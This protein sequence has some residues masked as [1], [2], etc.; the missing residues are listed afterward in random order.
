MPDVKI[1][2][3]T[4]SIPGV[5]IS[6]GFERFRAT[7]KEIHMTNS[8]KRNPTLVFVTE[9]VKGHYGIQSLIEISF[10]DLNKVLAELGYTLYQP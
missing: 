2:K 1:F 5:S 3:T 9:D 7:I 6:P 8:K 4:N 10:D